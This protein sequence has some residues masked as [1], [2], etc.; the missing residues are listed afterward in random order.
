MVNYEAVYDGASYLLDP[1]YGNFTGYRVPTG[2][3]G[4]TTSIQTAN[5]LKEVTNLLNQ[6][7]KQTEVSIVDPNVFEMIPQGQLNEIKR[8]NK[9]VG[10]ESSL[11]APIIDPAGVTEQGWSEENRESAEK[12][13][14]NIIERA[15][16]L[17]LNGNMPVTIHASAALPGSLKVPTKDGEQLHTL[18]AVDQESG[19]AIPIKGRKNSTPTWG[20]GH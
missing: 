19:K 3:L 6:G 18:I 15:H 9:L 16:E 10:A 8:L 17:D 20:K 2:S 7:M 12:Q 11:H 13:F 4:A 5:Q 1:G 14:S